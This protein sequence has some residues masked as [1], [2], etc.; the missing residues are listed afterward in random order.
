MT[1]TV[2]HFAFAKP[3]QN[4]RSRV[5]AKQL[6]AQSKPTYTANLMSSASDPILAAASEHFRPLAEMKVETLKTRKPRR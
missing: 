2:P 1:E 6:I 3:G 4:V 5:P